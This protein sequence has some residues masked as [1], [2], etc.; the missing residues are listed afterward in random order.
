MHH[1]ERNRRIMRMR[2]LIDTPRGLKPDGFSGYAQPN[3]S[4]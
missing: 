3:G 1:Q 4:R 2:V